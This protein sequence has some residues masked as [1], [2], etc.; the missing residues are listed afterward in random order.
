M[1]KPKELVPYLSVVFFVI[2]VVVRC[3]PHPYNIGAIGALGLFV[4]CFWS[5]RMGVLFAVAAMALSDVLGHWLGIESMGFYSGWLMLTVYA[6]MACSAGVGKF[7]QYLQRKKVPMA[8]LVPSGAV[9]AAILFFLITN[10]ASFLDPQMGYPAT[11]GGL[12]QCYSLAIPFAKGSF[13]GNLIF[14]GAFFGAYS[15]LK[16]RLFSTESSFE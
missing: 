7:V 2:A 6:A 5:A 15:L 12:L 8:F 16:Q 3:V 10:F 4:G 1:S 14:S 9:I 11:L 13:L